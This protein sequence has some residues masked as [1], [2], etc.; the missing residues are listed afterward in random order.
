MIDVEQVFDRELLLQVAQRGTGRGVKVAIIDTGVDA[1]HPALQGAVRTSQEVALSGRQF[2]C[3]PSTE[4]DPVGHGTACAGII[5]RLAPEAELHS[6]RVIGRDAAGTIDHL[7]FGLKW[8]IDQ[9]MHVINMSLGTVQQRQIWGLHQLVDAAYFKGQILVAAANNLRQESYPAAFASLI[10]V[11][12]E[13]FKDPLTFYYRLGTPVEMVAH[14]IYVNAPSPGGKFRWFTGTSFACPH[15]T[16]LVAKLK[17]E[18][19]GITPF[20]VKSL[21][22]CLRANRDSAHTS[23]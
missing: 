11:D 13:A 17:S 6:L 15:I 23:V 21:L 9:G 2:V 10:A 22:W 16:G 12:S 5:H 1:D 4:G 20:H 3:R 14:G 7:T 18:I 19:H 8:A